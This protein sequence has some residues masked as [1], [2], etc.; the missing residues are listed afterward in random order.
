VISDQTIKLRK[1]VFILIL[2][3]MQEPFYGLFIVEPC[4]VRVVIPINK[5][6]VIML[7][8]NYVAST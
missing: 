7:K 6:N 3:W 4:Y 5:P 2:L 1:T 8:K